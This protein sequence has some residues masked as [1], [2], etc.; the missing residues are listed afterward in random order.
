VS[1]GFPILLV[2][3]TE[4]VVVVVAVVVV[5]VVRHFQQIY[6]PTQHRLQ[7]QNSLQELSP[8]ENYPDRETAARRRS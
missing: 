4:R 6:T 8:P 3:E 1:R 2:T 7:K 5:V